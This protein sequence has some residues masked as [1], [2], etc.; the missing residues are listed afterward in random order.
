M[1]WPNMAHTSSSARDLVLLVEDDADNRELMTIFLEGAGFRV[2]GFESAEATLAKIG[3]AEPC[4]MLTDLWLPGLSGADLVARLRE[5]P[6]R[7]NLAAIALTGCSTSEVEA[8]APLL[9]AKVFQKPLAFDAVVGA[10]R[11]CISNPAPFA[12]VTSV[13][14]ER[15]HS[16]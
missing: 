2:L 14:R 11:A 8:S 16:F 4:A 12:S 6:K 15:L 13:A 3:D 9:F 10:V 7:R 5:H 1:V